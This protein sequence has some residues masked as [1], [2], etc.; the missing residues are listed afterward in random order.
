MERL[1]QRLAAR[2]KELA[3]RYA[4]PLPELDRQVESLEKKVSSHLEAMG[5]TNVV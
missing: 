4:E 2:I 3:E 5:F 1:S